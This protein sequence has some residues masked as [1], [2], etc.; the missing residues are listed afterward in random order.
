[1]HGATVKIVVNLSPQGKIGTM[2]PTGE[3]NYGIWSLEVEI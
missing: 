1:M 2:F 3:W